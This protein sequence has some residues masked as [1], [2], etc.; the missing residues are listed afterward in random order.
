MKNHCEIIILGW[1]MAP[2][3]LVCSWKISEDYLL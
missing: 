2:T 3:E 1:I